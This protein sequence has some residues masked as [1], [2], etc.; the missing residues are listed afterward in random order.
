MIP[1][2]LFI[3]GLTVNSIWIGLTIYL[4]RRLTAPY[5]LSKRQR[6][7]CFCA[8]IFVAL[9][10]PC[11]FLTR[12][13]RHVPGQEHL[14]FLGFATMGCV[15]VLVTFIVAR[16]LVLLAVTSL[17]RAFKAPAVLRP[18]LGI[19]WFYGLST[20]FVTTFPDYVASVK[21]C[22][23]RFSLLFI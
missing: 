19:A 6:I 20:V 14:A 10:V 13:M 3:F 21:H 2:R 17:R 4:Y 23:A 8:G 18:M 11:A 22:N 9:I 16:D 7:T 5:D 12:L 15:A 1:F